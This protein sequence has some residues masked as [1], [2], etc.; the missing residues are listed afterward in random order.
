MSE[1]REDGSSLHWVGRLE[2]QVRAGVNPRLQDKGWR[3]RVVPF[4]GYGTTDWVR[5][6]ARVLLV[7]PS[8][9]RSGPRDHRGWRRFMTVSVPGLPVTVEIGGETHVVV[10]GPDGYVD[11]RVECDLEPGWS[12][13]RIHVGDEPPVEAPVRV[14]GP[15]TTTGL[16][17]DIDDT[18]METNV[19]RPLVAFRNA[20]LSRESDRRTVPGM[21]ELCADIVG[22]RPDLFVVYLSTGAWNVAPPLQAFLARHGFP[23]GPLLLTDWGPTEAGWFRSGQDHKREQLKRLFSELPD[24]TWILLGDDGQHDPQVYAE[25]AREHPDRV[26]AIAIR[27]LTPTQHLVAHGTTVPPDG[28]TAPEPDVPAVMVAAPDGFGLRDALRERGVIR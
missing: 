18:V 28:D 25:A 2:R 11:V 6:G 26:V 15:G 21:G 3:P 17:S 5:V 27:Q 9:P 24:L 4:V 7:P 19:P 23:K 14:V 20:F 10:S 12:S 16:V 8:V 22:S 13:A 1:A